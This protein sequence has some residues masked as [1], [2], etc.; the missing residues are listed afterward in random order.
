MD[1]ACAVNIIT[2]TSPSTNFTKEV[3][4]EGPSGAAG[5]WLGSS[6]AQRLKP[7]LP[8]ARQEPKPLE[9]DVLTGSE[10][11]LR[12]L[13]FGHTCDRRGAFHDFSMAVY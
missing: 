9:T 10:G 1:Q 11:S 12:K 8:G 3:S 7:A 4:V 6:E 13:F 5:K 2:L